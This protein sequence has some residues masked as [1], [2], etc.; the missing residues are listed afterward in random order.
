MTDEKALEHFRATCLWGLITIVGEWLIFVPMAAFLAKS[1]ASS[2]E[3]A[4]AA[5]VTVGVVAGLWTQVE[6]FDQF[7]RAR[8]A[9]A[10]RLRVGRWP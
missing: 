3:V 10:I 5:L 7:R 2:G 6:R 9:I 4:M 1:F 8:K